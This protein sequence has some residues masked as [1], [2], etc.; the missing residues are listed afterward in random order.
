MTGILLHLGLFEGCLCPLN[1]L[2]LDKISATAYL[3]YKSITAPKR[4]DV[5]PSRTRPQ[6]PHNL[7]VVIMAK[8]SNHIAPLG[9]AVARLLA[10][11]RGQA[12]HL[13]EGVF[14]NPASFETLYHLLGDLNPKCDREKKVDRGLLL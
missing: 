7:T 14:I 13:V 12:G 10:P 5:S 1:C 3:L 9:C 2:T 6:C 11:S 4:D 8:L